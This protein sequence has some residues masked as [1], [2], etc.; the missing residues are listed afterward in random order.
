MFRLMMFVVLPGCIDNGV[1]AITDVYGSDGWPDIVVTPRTLDFGALGPNQEHTL[2]FTVG[3]TGELATEN[4]VL[5]VS[6]IT[7]DSGVDYTITAVD[8]HLH[9]EEVLTFLLPRGKENEFLVTFAPEAPLSYDGLITVHSDDDDSP[10][11]PVRL[12]GVGL[13]PELEISPNPLNFGET[14]SGCVLEHPLTLTNVGNADLVISEINLPE[15]AFS[16]ITGPDLPLTLVP[17]ASALVQLRFAPLEE[18]EYDEQLEV[19]SN[20]TMGVR[21]ATQLGRGH[22]PASYIDSFSLDA[23]PQADILFFVDQSGSMQDDREKLV[24]NLDGFITRLDTV[25][26]DWQLTVVTED[27]GCSAS[28]IIT[29]STPNYLELFTDAALAADEG[30]F[31]EAGLSLSYDAVQESADGHCNEGFVRPSALLH[32]ILVS[33]EPEQSAQPWDWYVNRLTDYKGNQ[34]LVKVSAVAGDVP[35]GCESTGNSAYPGIGYMEAA[36]ETGGEFLSICSDWASHVDT[37]A[38]A[39]V[40]REDYPLSHTPDPATIEVML[41]GETVHG[42]WHYDEPT[43]AVVFNENKLPKEGDELDI[44][45]SEPFTC[46][47]M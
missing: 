29:P 28:G 38:S 13:M 22:V 44:T 37:L 35:L 15:G 2:S 31:S 42:I 10:A 19:T 6:D 24:E 20:E 16:V 26:P 47:E 40:I 32:V 14:N 9:G 7:L 39:S 30:R 11:T 41:N 21:A 45:Y 36:Q 4:S 8:E 33:D 12:Y 3:N 18:R 23:N 34:F 5:Q 43:N 1:G 25:V 27:G 17:E 46:P